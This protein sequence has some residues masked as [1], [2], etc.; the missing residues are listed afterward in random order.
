MLFIN[1][2]GNIPQQRFYSFS[3]KGNHNANKVRFILARQQADID[4]TNYVCNLK[5]ESKEA[6]YKDLIMLN[7]VEESTSELVFEWT[8][9]NKSTQFRNLELQL[10]FLSTENESEVVWQTMIVEFELSDTIKVGDE[11]PTDKELSV[12]KQL[13][14]SVVA[15]EEQVKNKLEYFETTYNELKQLRDN[16]QLVQGS[17]YRITDYMTTTVQKES[18]S[19]GHQFDVIVQALSKNSLSENA[20][21]IRHRGDT[22]FES[23]ELKSWEIK[24]CLDND[25]TRF[26]WADEENGKGVIYYMKD[27]YGN[28]CPYDFKNIQFKRYLIVECQ[29]S[30]NLVDTY[31]GIKQGYGYDIDE[32]S[33]IWCYTFTWINE[34]DEV[35]DCSIVGQTLSTDDNTEFKGVIG[36]V[37]KGCSS[38]RLNLPEETS[39]FQFALNNI[40]IQATFSY[41]SGVFYGMYGNKFGVGCCLITL[42]MNSNS[43]TFG[44]DCHRNT[45]GVGCYSNTFGDEFSH[46]TF[47]NDCYF[48]VFGDYCTSNIFGSDCFANIFGSEC[49]N[50]E[51]G[52][53]CCR[54]VFGVYCNSNI[55]G[56]DCSHNTFDKACS[57]NIFGSYCSNN[58]FGCSCSSIK[59]GDVH[60]TMN[61]YHCITI[62]S[63]CSYLYIKSNGS[64][65][66]Q[67]LLKNIHI[68]LGVK[69][70]DSSNRKTITVNRNLNYETSVKPI[71]SQEVEV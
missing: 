46:N 32:E 15:L 71:N 1:Y 17:L 4:L 25:T 70:A 56:E 45:L 69:G 2:K 61:Y 52:V 53:F 26:L 3:V 39:R 49:Y 37:I 54:N 40:V 57:D 31:F 60:S 21:A 28:E 34:D 62:E 68:H 7:L 59:F 44:D 6:N 36:N 18:R 47:G 48:N 13:E 23:C 43:V 29:N 14:E 65:S 10:E 55:F 19:A 42:G 67:N 66:Y 58:V 20:H 22:Y 64:G 27:E 33:F 51:L 16:G 50:N 12:L 11:K 35:E 38:F 30:P 63:G 24:Y 5:V 9:T 8:M 41:D